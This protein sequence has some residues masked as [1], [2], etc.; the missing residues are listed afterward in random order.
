LAEFTRSYLS[1]CTRDAS[2]WAIMSE[3]PLFPLNTVLFP[4]GRLPLRVFEKRYMDMVSTCMKKEQPFGV[5]LIRAGAE[6][7][8]AAQPYP[9]GTTGHIVAWDMS[10]AGILNI[11]VRGGCCFRVRRTYVRPDQLLIGEVEFQPVEPAAALP[12]AHD[13]LRELLAKILEQLG[14]QYYFPPVQMGNAGWVAHRLT[15]FLPLPSDLKQQ[16]LEQPHAEQK[17]DLLTA[18]IAAA[19]V[20]AS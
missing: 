18:A 14:E 8:Q 17:L 1:G 20:D 2:K 6:V 7:G 16:V 4:E 3:L 10:Q 12:V 9:F 15:E 13:D 11:V 5:C 19:R